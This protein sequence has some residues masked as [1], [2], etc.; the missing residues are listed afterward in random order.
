M[1]KEYQVYECLG[2]HPFRK[3]KLYY[4]TICEH[5]DGTKDTSYSEQEAR[6]KCGELKLEGK[7]FLV[8]EVINV[9]KEF[10]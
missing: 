4:I 8:K 10:V 9:T 1:T 2:D 6:A 5:N 3:G 7:K